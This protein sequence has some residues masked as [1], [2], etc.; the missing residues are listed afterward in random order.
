MTPDFV[1]P[2]INAVY[3]GKV[4]PHPDIAKPVEECLFEIAEPIFFP[5]NPKKF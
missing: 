3:T 5:K 2:A 4:K 1:Y